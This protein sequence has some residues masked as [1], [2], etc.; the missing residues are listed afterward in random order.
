[1]APG[2]SARVIGAACSLTVMATVAVPV[3]AAPAFAGVGPAAAATASASAPLKILPLGDSI[4]YGRWSETTSS[5][6]VD[7][8]RRLKAAGNRVDFVGSV[9]SGAPATADLDNEGHPGW[10]ID[11]L[12]ARLDGWLAAY[13]PDVVLLLAGT[14]DMNQ[15]YQMD[16]APDRL[17]AMIDQIHVDRPTAQIFV[18]TLPASKTPATQARIDVFNAAIPAIAA[19]R[20]SVV[21]VVDQSG[22]SGVLLSDALH[23]NDYGFARMSY[24][25]YRAMEKVYNRRARRWPAVGNPFLATSARMCTVATTV[26]ASG[27]WH[28]KWDC[29]TWHLRPRTTTVKVWQR[30][31][32]VVVSRKVWVKP[33]RKIVIRNAKK[34]RVYVAGHFVHKRRT[35]LRWATA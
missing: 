30:L 18:Q 35:V 24:N 34:S 33:Y 23:P 22:I 6:R 27:R 25:I 31:R 16:T 26:D 21:H 11:Q 12:A 10:R 29:A 20:P 1:M 32:P 4:T 14:N 19:G 8:Q 7:L 3:A 15:N 17:A 13:K 28:Y 2:V 9:K 5:Y